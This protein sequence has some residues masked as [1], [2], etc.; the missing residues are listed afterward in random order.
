[1]RVTDLGLTDV[2]HLVATEIT[3]LN[4]HASAFLKACGGSARFLETLTYKLLPKL[5]SGEALS[6]R[7]IFETAESVKIF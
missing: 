3:Q 4:G 1:M 5:Q 2:Q 7:M 6:D